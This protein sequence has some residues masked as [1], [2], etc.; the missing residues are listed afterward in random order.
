MQGLLEV[1]VLRK[2]F[3]VRSG[4]FRKTTQFVHAVD[5]VSF[6][7][8]RGETLALVGESG[9]GKTTLA[10]LILR[11]IE[12]DEGSVRLMEHDLL[13]TDAEELRKLRAKMQMIFQD[14]LASLNPRRTVGQILSQP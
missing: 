7:V 9:C 14:P 12:P 11:F 3:P 13:R 1:D 8:Q 10:K 4:L 6:A 2:Y 5:G